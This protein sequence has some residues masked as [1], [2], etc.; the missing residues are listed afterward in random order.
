MNE[1]QMKIH[2]PN[3]NEVDYQ[4][5]IGVNLRPAKELTPSCITPK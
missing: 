1:K 4:N 2:N 5:E 3:L